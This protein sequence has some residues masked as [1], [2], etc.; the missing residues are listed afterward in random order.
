MRGVAKAR[1]TRSQ[2]VSAIQVLD[3]LS[4][5]IDNEAEDSI[6]FHGKWYLEGGRSNWIASQAV[7]RMQAVNTGF[8]N[9][10]SGPSRSR[11]HLTR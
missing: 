10:N 2:I 6:R 3:Q 8:A 11:I 4:R 7:Q 1:A 5:R 9:S